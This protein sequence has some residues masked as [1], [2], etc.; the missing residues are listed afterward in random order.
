MRPALTRASRSPVRRAL[1]L[2][3]GASSTPVGWLALRGLRRRVAIA[4]AQCLAMAFAVAIPLA[5]QFAATISADE[6]Y[7]AALNLSSRDSTATVELRGGG[8]PDNYQQLQNRAIPAVGSTTGA[9]M[10]TIAEYGTISS[11]TIRSLNGA[12]FPLELLP[13]LKAVFYPALEQKAELFNGSWPA[14]T[15][16]GGSV[17][18]TVSEQAALLYAW[19]VGDLVCI[20]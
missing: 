3:F 13:P 15:S 17:E 4:T 19:K 2:S 9:R 11:F 16:A 7:L 14:P 1:A 6:G 8:T 20:A 12:E 10:A 5:L 18:A